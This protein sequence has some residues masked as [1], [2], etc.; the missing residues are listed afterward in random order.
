MANEILNVK[1]ETKELLKRLAYKSGRTMRDIVADALE[2]YEERQQEGAQLCQYL[3]GPL[4]EKLTQLVDEVIRTSVSQV[5]KEREEILKRE[6]NYKPWLKRT[7]TDDLEEL[8]EEDKEETL[9][10]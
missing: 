4:T 8:P 5:L 2:M 9:D 7:D 3:E 10:D 6:R 1:P